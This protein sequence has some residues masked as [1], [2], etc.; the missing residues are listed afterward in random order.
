MKT[1][2]I[3]IIFVIVAIAQLFIPTKMIL[4]QEDILDNGT[5]YKFRT[6]P[7]DPSDP[8][9][10]KYITLNYEMNSVQSND[11]LWIRK[12]DVY[13]YIKKDDLGFAELYKVS[14]EPLEIE[15]DYVVGT[16]NYYN[17]KTKK[18]TFNVPFN[19]F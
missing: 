7:V 17:K 8:F 1:L 19:R 3:F 18:L 9:R 10:G 12:Q 15:N 14:N 4:E 11:T 16:V 13:V 2:H 5:V 6:Q